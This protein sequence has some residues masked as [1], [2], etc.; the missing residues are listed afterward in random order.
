MLLKQKHGQLLLTFSFQTLFPIYVSWR[1][2]YVVTIRS[3]IHMHGPQP[4]QYRKYSVTSYKVQTLN[5]MRVHGYKSH[6]QRDYHLYSTSIALSTLIDYSIAFSTS[7]VFLSSA[8]LASLTSLESSY[9]A[10]SSSITLYSLASC[11]SRVASSLAAFAS[12]SVIASSDS[13]SISHKDGLQKPALK[14]SSVK[15]TIR[16]PKNW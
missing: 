11:P 16:Q 6:F 7:A 4:I 10:S 1:K 8:T 3:F 2:D 13:A 9:F 5:K 14:I 12:F 15:A